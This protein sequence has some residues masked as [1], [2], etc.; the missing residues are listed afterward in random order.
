[1]FEQSFLPR[2]R[3]R[4]P[5]TVAVAFVSELLFVGVLILIPLVFVQTLPSAEL[6]STMLY[7]PPP[8]PPPPPP[9]PAANQPVLVQAPRVFRA[10]ELIAPTRI[11]TRVAIIHDQPITSAANY[12]VVG[13]VLGGVPG[14]QLGGVVGSVLSSVPAVV[15]PPPKPEIKS[16]PK[17]AAPTPSIIR[18]GGDVQA[19]KLVQRVMPQYPWLARQA[20]LEGTV[21]LKAIIGADGRIQNLQVLSGNPLLIPAAMSAVEQ[22]VYEPTYLNGNPVKIETE[23]SVHFKLS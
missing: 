5:W 11:P 4:K 22:W 21:R 3:T 1:M 14:G 9:A 13:G 20:R 23:I 10:N 19:A 16:Q 6:M 8:P 17:T 7:A 18:V 12:G 15:A 2:G